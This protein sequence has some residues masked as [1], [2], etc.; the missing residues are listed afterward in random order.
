[1]NNLI[2]FI[3]LQSFTNILSNRAHYVFCNL[4]THLESKEVLYFGENTKVNIEISRDSDYHN[5]YMNESLEIRN[6]I[7][8]NNVPTFK[9]SNN[10]LIYEKINISLNT[11]KDFNIGVKYKLDIMLHEKLTNEIINKKIVDIYSHEIKFEKNNYPI[12]LNLEQY[13]SSEVLELLE[14]VK[15]ETLK[16]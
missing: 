7:L 15:K 8:A 11:F 5:K 9:N 12:L 16:Q 6:T 10:Y 4:I 13:H 1:M 2:R 3:P 14:Y